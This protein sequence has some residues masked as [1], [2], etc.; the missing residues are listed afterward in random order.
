[1]ERLNFRVTQAMN[2][3]AARKFAAQFDL[4]LLTDLSLPELQNMRSECCDFFKNK[5]LQVSNFVVVPTEKGTLS[6]DYAILAG[7]HHTGR[8][9]V[10][11]SDFA[12]KSIRQSTEKQSL[13]LELL[14]CRPELGYEVD[15]NEFNLKIQQLDDQIGVL[16]VTIGMPAH[17]K[18]TDF[19]IDLVQHYVL[20]RRAAG[21]PIW[22]HVDAAFGFTEI[23]RRKDKQ[24][25]M[26]MQ[27]A[28]SWTINPHKWVGPMG[29]SLVGF[30]DGKLPNL[31]DQKYFSG[32][33]TMFGSS[34]SAYSLAATWH[35]VQRPG[36]LSKLE[37]LSKE[38]FSNTQKLAHLFVKHGFELICEPE[39][40]IIAINLSHEKLGHFGG[41]DV[42]GVHLKS[43]F[44]TIGVDADLCHTEHYYSLRFM[45]NPV[46]KKLFHER[47]QQMDYI[48]GS[49]FISHI[50][51]QSR[52][53]AKPEDLLK[54]A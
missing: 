50:V 7:Q 46:A 48:L 45:M 26:L 29:L 37:K 43:A 23:L 6:N 8:K 44:A 24:L 18:F 4:A 47:L 49:L 32:I 52:P 11:A 54:V 22:L 12:H 2:D 28:D 15:R 14:P 51:P 41:P 27:H 36:A 21:K 13:Q 38:V 30:K 19:P 53:P 31:T 33:F 1:M 40:R 39:T 16:V 42:L 35:I 34:Q 25:R 3:N 9:L 20:Q 5:V 17:G 10:V